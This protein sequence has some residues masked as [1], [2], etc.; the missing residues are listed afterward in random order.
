MRV[1]FDRYFIVVLLQFGGKSVLYRIQLYYTE[2]LPSFYTVFH[3]KLAGIRD[4][5]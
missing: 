5:I 1:E 4:I 2:N 3:I